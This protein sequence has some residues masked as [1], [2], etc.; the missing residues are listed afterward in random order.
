MATDALKGKVLGGTN[1]KEEAFKKNQILYSHFEPRMEYAWDNGVGIGIYLS[2]LKQG[3]ILGSYCKK[4]DRTVLPARAFCEL[5]FR[6]TDGWVEVQD[7]GTVETFSV[8]RI[9]FDASRL[10]KG[11][12]P[13]IPAVISIDG[14]SEKMGIMH[15]LDEVAIE[16]IH[17][18]MKV[19][20][21][22]RPEE[23]R[24]GTIL[25]IRYFRPVKKASK[26]RAGKKP[27]PK[28]RK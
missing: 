26:P 2:G 27:S 20:A 11:E 1:V 25:D 22:W 18:G 4:C 9:H 21:V 16:D 15:M 3:K 5:C 8:S 24:E 12:K 28:K 7:T 6:P 17:I 23:E 13:Y 10:K 14:A 19:E